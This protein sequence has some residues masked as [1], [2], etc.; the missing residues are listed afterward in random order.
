MTPPSYLTTFVH[1][2]EDLLERIEAAILA[3]ETSP[4]TPS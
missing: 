1:E 2:V 4:A 3:L